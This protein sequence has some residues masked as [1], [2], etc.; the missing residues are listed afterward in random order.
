[1]IAAELNF[2]VKYSQ[3]CLVL[4]LQSDIINQLRSEMSILIDFQTDRKF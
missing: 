4:V 1:M 3:V 2:P